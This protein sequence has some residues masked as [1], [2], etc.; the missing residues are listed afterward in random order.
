MNRL[1]A[2]DGTSLVFDAYETARP[3]AA[4]LFL[5][6]WSDHAGRWAST[7][8]RLQA[9]GFAA[10]LLD[11][12]GHGRSGG[13]RGHLSRFSQLLGDLQAFR[14]AVRLRTEA[15][16]VLLAELLPFLQRKS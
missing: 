9:A 7:G 5:H 2:P 12:R 11:L 14:R 1:N 13:P 4:V 10:Y 15:P 6:G 16:Q 3:K 8:R